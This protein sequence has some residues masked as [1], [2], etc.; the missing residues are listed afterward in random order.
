MDSAPVVTQSRPIHRQQHRLPCTDDPLRLLR[1]LCCGSGWWIIGYCQTLIA[2][3]HKI[4]IFSN[5]HFDKYSSERIQW[6]YALFL[7]HYDTLLP[8]EVKWKIPKLGAGKNLVGC[9]APWWCMTIHTRPW[10]RREQGCKPVG[11]RSR[12]LWEGRKVRSQGNPAAGNRAPF[13]MRSDQIRIPHVCVKSPTL[14]FALVLSQFSPS[15][16]R[17]F[18]V[19]TVAYRRLPTV[20][21]TR[22]CWLVCKPRADYTT[23]LLFVCWLRTPA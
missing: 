1:G 17:F 9:R 16:K 4:R 20:G 22:T 2:A 10:Q 3:I 21:G 13:E 5:A 23:G 8:L 6:N 12:R 15:E 14:R 11:I 19:Q 18:F 7:V